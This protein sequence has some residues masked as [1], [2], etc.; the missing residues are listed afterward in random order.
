MA[1]FPILIIVKEKDISKCHTRLQPQPG[2][3]LPLVNLVSSSSVHGVL[4]AR[5]QQRAAISFSTVHLT[6]G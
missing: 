3:G 2:S 1:L 4:Q 5:I 6:Q